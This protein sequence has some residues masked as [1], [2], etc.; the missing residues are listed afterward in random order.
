MEVTTAVI[1]TAPQ[2]RVTNPDAMPIELLESLG[3][4]WYRNYA[5]LDL[6]MRGAGSMKQG[7]A[8]FEHL[9]NLLDK[10]EAPGGID[11][12]TSAM[13]ELNR[14]FSEHILTFL[15][16]AGL[17]LLATY[18]RDSRYLTRRPIP[19]SSPQWDM[20]QWREVA[21]CS[22]QRFLV[23]GCV[24]VQDIITCP[25]TKRSMVPAPSEITNGDE[26]RHPEP[27]APS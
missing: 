13:A 1:Q 9:Q 16:P 22:L 25:W 20:G 14:L 23:L 2:D 24:N 10:V 11:A 8:V 27:I 5:Y 4:S 6:L 21:I 18:N 26:P 12:K 19:S 17:E 3:D 7:Q 15:G